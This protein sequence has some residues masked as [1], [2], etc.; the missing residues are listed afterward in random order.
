MGFNPGHGLNV[1]DDDDSS[2][3]MGRCTKLFINA[4]VARVNYNCNTKI[5][6]QI[7]VLD[8]GTVQS[9]GFLFLWE[10]RFFPLSDALLDKLHGCTDQI[11]SIKQIQI[12]FYV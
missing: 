7:D 8:W 12:N 1:E 6:Q 10:L 4:K 3:G 5:N 9:C 2:S 11:L